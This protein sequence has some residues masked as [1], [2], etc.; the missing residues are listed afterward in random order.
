MNIELSLGEKIRLLRKANKKTQRDLADL[1]RVSDKT[2]SKYECNRI[3]PDINICKQLA[4]IFDVSLDA[5]LRDKTMVD[6]ETALESKPNRQELNY[7]SRISNLP[8]SKK[9]IIDTVL[10]ELERTGEEQS[11]VGE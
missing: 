11:A 9:H 4:I 1:L 2:L 3:I 5:L 6:M 8:D 7:D 10:V